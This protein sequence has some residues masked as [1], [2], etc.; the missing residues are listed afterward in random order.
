MLA[1]APT[2]DVVG[3][4]AADVAG[5]AAVATV[6]SDD[7]Q[8]P[9][10][11]G[12][13]VLG[14]PAGPYLERASRDALTA[15]GAQAQSLAAAGFRIIEAPVLDDM[16]GVERLLFVISRFEA[17]APHG[18]W[19]DRYGELYQAGTAETIRA[20]RAVGGDEYAAALAGRAEVASRL[21]DARVRAGIDLWIT[22][23]ATG[24]APA[25]LATT[26]DPVMSTPWSLAGLPAVSIPAG[27][28]AGCP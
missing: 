23:A 10:G 12:L 21:A 19:F 5:L 22:P 9:A 13:P 17:A 2:L 15:F 8:A 7:W 25:G 3:C 18:G 1:Y 26:G 27:L 4:F 6:L 16:A 24:P 14:I 20:G 28:S 11:T